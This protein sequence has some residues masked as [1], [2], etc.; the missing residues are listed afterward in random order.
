MST[1]HIQDFLHHI[2]LNLE[3]FPYVCIFGL[4]H[5]LD[6][7]CQTIDSIFGGLLSSTLQ[8]SDC[9][10]PGAGCKLNLSEMDDN[11]SAS[12]YSRNTKTTVYIA[13]RGETVTRSFI[14]IHG[15]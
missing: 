10:Q 2:Y 1:P 3:R 6:S 14:F 8:S 11:K 12:S 13:V 9:K 15:L 4:S 5:N 7:F